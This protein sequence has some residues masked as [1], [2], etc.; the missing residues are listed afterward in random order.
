[1]RVDILCRSLGRQC[2]IAEYTLALAERL[3]ARPISNASQVMNPVVMIEYEP[4][5][6]NSVN[7]LLHE[8]RRLQ[9]AIVL[10]DII[11]E[12]PS[13]IA[14]RLS[15][16]RVLSAVRAPNGFT[17]IVMPQADYPQV[18][19]SFH[20]PARLKLGAFG[21][22]LPNKRYNSLIGLS[23]RLGVPMLI[24]AAQATASPGIG[25]L[26][27]RYLRSLLREAPVSVEIDHRFL[28]NE[29][30]VNRLHGCSHLVCAMEDLGLS[31]GSLRL[32]SQARRPIISLPCR[33]AEEI[34]A[35]V[36]ESW[37]DVSLALLAQPLPL[38]HFVD[39]LEDYQRVLD[40]LL[41]CQQRLDVLRTEV[42]GV[43]HQN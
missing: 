5:L 34:G 17:N 24:L 3:Q 39:G 4:A 2:G 11:R 29:G 7:D 31:S 36:V 32:M 41:S 20:E 15:E 42:L 35:C 10:V 1:M 9:P 22:A 13:D 26:S 21:F 16:Q 37:D 28:S 38:T 30:I 25:R 19:V 14:S 6:Y 12:L 8:I 43:Y 18:Q 27:R 23:V 33:G 40:E